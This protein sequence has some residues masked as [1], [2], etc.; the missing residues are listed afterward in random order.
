MLIYL[1]SSLSCSLS[2]GDRLVSEIMFRGGSS[3]PPA[4]F[5]TYRYLRPSAA[6]AVDRPTRRV[7]KLLRNFPIDEGWLF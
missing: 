7:I 5:T 6:P 4:Y 2:G 1:H 3:T